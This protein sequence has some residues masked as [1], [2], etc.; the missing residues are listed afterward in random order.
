V[1]D[2][3]RLQQVVWNLLSNATKFTP[4]GGTVRVH[5]Q[6]QGSLV[7]LVVSDTGA[8]IEASFLPYVFDRFRQGGSGSTR[9]Y[10]G[11]GLG[12]SIV[13]HLV[14]MHGGTV[15]AHSAGLDQGA[16]FI[17][18]LPR[19]VS[20]T[21]HSNGSSTQEVNEDVNE[22]YPPELA[23]LRV[24]VVDDQHTITELLDEVL[25]ASGA[26][27]RTTTTAPEALVLL[28]TWRPDVLVSDIAM[29]DEDG[30][31]LI[32]AV[33]ALPAEAGGTT[34]ALALTAYV[35]VED[36]VRVLE[37]GFQQYVSKPVEPTDLRA[38]IARLSA[39]SQPSKL[40]D[41]G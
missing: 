25:S 28:K 7:Q 33:R 30:Y 27:V 31:W 40:A 3:N 24:L 19:R 22:D 14:E 9:I 11:L 20:S 13:R 6:A 2:P 17:V 38:A 26:V 37:A 15:E 4:E 5:G 23:G 12:L 41:S 35:R 29:P 1:G 18:S 21:V 32:R 39:F 10:G 16:T 34:P 8:G 36:R